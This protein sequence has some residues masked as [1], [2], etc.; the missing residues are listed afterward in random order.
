M[1]VEKQITGFLGEYSPPIRDELK[2]ARRKLRSLFPRGFEPVFNNYNALVFAYSPTSSSAR[3]LMSIAG[4]PRWM[5]RGLTCGFDPAVAGHRYLDP[6]P[7]SELG[8]GPG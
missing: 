1:S 8:H 2:R 4:Y 5:T 3:C 7:A 6:Q